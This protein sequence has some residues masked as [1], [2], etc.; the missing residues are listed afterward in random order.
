M[1]ISDLGKPSAWL[2][3]ARSDLVFADPLPQ[4]GLLRELMCMHAQQAAEKALKAVLVYNGIEPPYTHDI[5]RLLLLVASYVEVPADIDAAGGLT[6]Y[7]VSAR[8]PDDLGEI[9]EAEWAD[10]VATARAVVAWAEGV[11]GG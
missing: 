8:Y 9:D 3:I 6:Q 11:V 7:A 5:R 4:P 1:S 2:T 10:A